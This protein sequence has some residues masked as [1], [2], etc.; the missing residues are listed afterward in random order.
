MATTSKPLQ[1]FHLAFP[2]SDLQTV[3]KFYVEV[4]G[5]K[6]GREDNRWIDFDFYGHQISAHLTEAMP[7]ATTNLVDGKAV[8]VSH[9]GMILQWNDW[10]QLR[11]R[12]IAASIT[13]L[14]KPHIRFAGQAGE[15]AT[16]FLTDPSGNGLEFKSFRNPDS[17][18]AH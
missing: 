6:T 4:L 3:R 16:M 13:F 9:F 7:V 14:I 15:Q 18:F 10:H 12:L 5:C 2:V 17:I 8:P 1:P 11:D